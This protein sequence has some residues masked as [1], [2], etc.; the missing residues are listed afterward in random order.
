MVDSF[1]SIVVPG[2]NRNG[3][4]SMGRGGC[5]YSWLISARA[6]IEASIGK[7]AF[8]PTGIALMFSL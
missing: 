5:S 7:M 2:S 8:L 1:S 4:C 6:R 3:V